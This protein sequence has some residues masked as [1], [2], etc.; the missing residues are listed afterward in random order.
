MEVD[1][2]IAPG[3]LL[4]NNL[5]SFPSIETSRVCHC[6]RNWSALHRPRP[7]FNTRRWFPLT[8]CRPTLTT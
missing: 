6:N 4:C 5:F 3:V 2:D 1:G 8:D 7:S